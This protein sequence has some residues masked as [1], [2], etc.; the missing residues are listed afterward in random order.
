MLPQ[1]GVGRNAERKCNKEGSAYVEPFL[2]LGGG[3]EGDIYGFSKG[4]GTG[5]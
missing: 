5:V 4:C 1:T 2:Y 3:M